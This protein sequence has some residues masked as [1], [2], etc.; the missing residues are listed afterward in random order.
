MDIPLTGG[1][2]PLA[3]GGPGLAVDPRLASF[4]NAYTM[5]TNHVDAAPQKTTHTADAIVTFVTRYLGYAVSCCKYLTWYR[6]HNHVTACLAAWVTFGP[7]TPNKPYTNA[8]SIS[9]RRTIVKVISCFTYEYAAD[10][11]DKG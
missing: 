10:A 6:S 3:P 11:A 2:I 4:T 5:H 1:V 9:I 7:S 8:L